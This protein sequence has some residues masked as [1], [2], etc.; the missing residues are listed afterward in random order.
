M[1][2]RGKRKSELMVFERAYHCY[3]GEGDRPGDESVSW[4]PPVDIFE[5]DESYVVHAEL[6]GVDKGDIH[7]EVV[8]AELSIRG[9]RKSDSLCCE[10]NYQRIESSNG[11][12][13]RIFSLPENLQSQGMDASLKDGVLNI[14]IPKSRRPKRM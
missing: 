7:I 5:T 4:V 14:M 10:E 9:E 2:K 3:W 13:H 1:P 11:K 6:P 12:F 8:G